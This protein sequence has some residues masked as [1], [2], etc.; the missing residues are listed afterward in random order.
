MSARAQ[1]KV[2]HLAVSRESLGTRLIDSLLN[3]LNKGQW[4]NMQACAMTLEKETS[5][6]MIGCVRVSAFSHCAALHSI[7]SPSSQMGCVY[8]RFSLKDKPKR[9][10]PQ[11]TISF[12]HIPN[13]QS[14]SH[15]PVLVTHELWKKILFLLEIIICLILAG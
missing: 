8:F 4:G 3:S 1:S 9:K 15:S 5:P 2:T 11:S 13:Q 7:P 14:G 10:D 12:Q 6:S